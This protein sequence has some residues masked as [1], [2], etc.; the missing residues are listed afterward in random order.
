MSNKRNSI[1]TTVAHREVTQWQGPLPPPESLARY[2]QVIPGSAQ[3][4][5]NMAVEE[6]KHRHK[7]EDKESK[8]QYVVVLASMSFALLCVLSLVGL[9]FY[10]ISKGTANTAL[11]SIISA[12]AAVGGIFGAKKLL[13]L[14]KK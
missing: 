6:Q 11:A 5:I 12:I 13:S 9:V 4:I 14:M 1:N 7:S 2:D 3:T 8:R 10:A